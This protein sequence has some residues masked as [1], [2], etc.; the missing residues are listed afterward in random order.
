MKKRKTHEEYIAEID[1]SNYNVTVIGEYI[2]ART[3]I[4]HKCNVCGYKWDV[5]PDNI[6]RGHKCPVCMHKAIGQPPEYRNSIWASDHK[7]RL[8]KYLSEEQMK[9]YMP[10]SNKRIDIECKFCGQ[11]KNMVIQHLS[12]YG[13]ACKCSDGKSYPNKF[14]YNML[15]QLN[16]KYIPEKSFDWSNKKVYDIY[17]PKFNCIVENHGIHHYEDNIF[18][19][20]S[21]KEEQE[22]DANKYCMAIEN[23]IEYYVIID[24]RR[25]EK[26]FIKNSIIK[27]EIA[28]ILHFNVEDINWNNCHEF[29]LS[30]LAKLAADYWENGYS[31]KEIADILSINKCTAKEYLMNLADINLCSYSVENSRKRSGKNI[32]NARKMLLELKT[33]TAIQN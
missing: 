7:D 5:T 25:S 23:G 28:S 19:M 9:S 10:N 33:D 3:P 11:Q 1:K 32:S 17:I 21:L 12:D 18:R 2:N 15:D 8:S 31:T 22:N 29:A 4:L 16:I 20:R 30:S 26:E 27:S 14:V 24:C 6:L 13:M